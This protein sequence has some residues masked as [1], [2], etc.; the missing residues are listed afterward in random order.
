MNTLSFNKKQEKGQ[1]LVEYALILV[2]VAIVSIVVLTLLGNSTS[3]KFGAIVVRITGDSTPNTS[4]LNANLE[5]CGAYPNMGKSSLTPA[6]AAVTFSTYV[7]TDGN[8][9][10]VYITGT[11]A[12]SGFELISSGS[13][14]YPY[15]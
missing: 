10:D 13:C 1:G 2:L 14:D 3:G 12:P 4:I 5:F 6:V 9:N 7:G 15:S 8:G 11:K